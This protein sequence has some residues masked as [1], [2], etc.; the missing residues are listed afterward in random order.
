MSW[1]RTILAGVALALMLLLYVTDAMIVQRRTIIQ[2]NDSSLSPGINKSEVVEIHLRNPQGE[3]VLKKDRGQ[4]RLKSPEDAAADPEI[5]DALLINVTGAR[6]NNE[7]E[8]KN[9]AEFGLASPDI[10]LTLT[11][12]KG[13]T[14]DLLVGNE[15]TYTG[16]AYAKFPKTQTVFTVGIQV[17]NSLLRAPLDFRRSRLFDVDIANLDA[18]TGINIDAR[19]RS[20]TLKNETG[21]WKVTAPFDTAAEPELVNDYLKKV[22]L[23]RAGLFL[24][25]ASDKPT[26]MAVAVQALTSPTLVMTLERGKG[27]AQRLVVAQV[28]DPSAGLYVAQRGG[29]DEIMVLRPETVSALDQDANY[30]RSRMIF[31]LVPADVG[32]LSIEIGRARTDLARNDKGEWEFVGDATRRVDQLGVNARLETLLH[33]KIKEFVET[34]PRDFNIY[35]LQPPRIKYSVTDKA[36][37]RTEA[38]DTGRSETGGGP[39]VVYAR[40]KGEDAVF[41][42]EL[43]AELFIT[44]DNV[45]DHNFARTDFALID[46][47]ELETNQQK[48]TYKRE[49]NEWK[50]QRPAQT[51]FVTADVRKVANLIQ[52]INTLPYAKDF[53][54]AGEILISPTGESPLIVRLYGKDSKELLNLTLGKRLPNTTY[55]TTG[56]DRNFEVKNTD[57]TR[58][59]NAV[60]TL[61]E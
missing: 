25:Q 9:L 6:K 41:T 37:A 30:F 51:A 32:L 16:Q 23:L 44:P 4:W 60:Q 22:G 59:Q 13:A 17:R 33:T 57:I 11:P 35:G 42:M 31:S 48:Y 49:G 36:K 14:F 15:S 39:A 18:Y 56:K 26:S 12:E 29:D 53:A 40:R 8:A 19:G 50:V 3:A 10:A 21:R 52:N 43:S 5:V 47:F 34:A 61:I 28:G 38:V 27:Q 54:S 58:L 20:L 46:H 24:T 1:R 7:V 55:V 45:S 2:V